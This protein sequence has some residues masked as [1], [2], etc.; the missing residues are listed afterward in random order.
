MDDNLIER[1]KSL[2]IHQKQLLSKLIDKIASDT[3]NN[4]STRSVSRVANPHF[5]TSKGISVAIGDT[6]QVLNN[7]KT[8]KNGDIVTIV[9]FNKTFIAIQL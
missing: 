7:R 9:K 6:F 3:N 8:G 1:I 2:N 5:V 4:T